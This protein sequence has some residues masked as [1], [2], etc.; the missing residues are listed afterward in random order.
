MSMNVQNKKKKKHK[1]KDIEHINNTFLIFINWKFENIYL[2]I[3]E[4]ETKMRTTQSDGEM[5]DET[6]I[7]QFNLN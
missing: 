5:F 4:H 1:K 7:I 2:Y 6:K 3:Y